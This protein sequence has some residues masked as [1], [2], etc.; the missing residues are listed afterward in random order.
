MDVKQSPLVS[1]ITVVLNNK[2]TV[3]DTIKNIINQSYEKIEYIIIDG[4]STDGTLEIINE[5][6]EKIDKLISEPDKGI[7]DAMNKGIKIAKGEVISF[8]NSDDL[9]AGYS[10]IK[11]VLSTMKKFDVDSCYGDLIYVDRVNPSKRIRFWKAGKFERNNFKKGWMPP[12]PTFFVKKYIYEKY[13][14]FNLDFPVVADYELMLRLLYKNNIST[15]YI[16]EI[17]VKMRTG[18]ISKPSII[19]VIKN[20]LSCYRAW[21]ANGLRPKTITFLLKPFSK[22]NQFL[23]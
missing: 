13:G 5:Y 9:Y 20:T 21:K 22:V 15:A 14:L 17:V 10:V 6:K 23:K 16:P 19:N 8:L 2:K 18:G 1:I 12:F 11:K 7:F 4:G 3:E